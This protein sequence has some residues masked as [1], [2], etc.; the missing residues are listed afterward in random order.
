MGLDAFGQR[1]TGEAQEAQGR[2]VEL[3][4]RR[5]AAVPVR[6]VESV[7]DIKQA[8]PLRSPTRQGGTP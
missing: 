8:M 6:H 7:A 4:P 5:P 2:I 1:R 3:R